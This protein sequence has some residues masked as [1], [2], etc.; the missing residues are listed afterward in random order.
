[1]PTVSLMPTNFSVAGGTSRRAVD[2]HERLAYTDTP[3]G[4][5]GLAAMI[6]GGKAAAMPLDSWVVRGREAE[7]HA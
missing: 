1:M 4:I 3:G 7:H 2:K 5:I 6:W